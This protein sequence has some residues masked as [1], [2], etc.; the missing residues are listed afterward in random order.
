M[1]YVRNGRI[2]ATRQRCAQGSQVPESASCLSAFRGRG[3]GVRGRSVRPAHS[4]LVQDYARRHG[5]A[6][7]GQHHLR[8]GYRRQSRRYVHRVEEF[9]CQKALEAKKRP[10]DVIGNAVHVM[11][12]ATGEMAPAMAAGISKM[13]WD[14]GDIVKLVEGYE[15]SERSAA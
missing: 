6:Y 15:E 2:P 9:R 1:A 13:L 4:G 8:A 14:V 10:A 12:I 3:A 11:R 7:R 5:K